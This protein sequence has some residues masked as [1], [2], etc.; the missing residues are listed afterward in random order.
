[1]TAATERTIPVFV[2][3]D[4]SWTVD[5]VIAAAGFRGELDEWWA[6]VRLMDRCESEAARRGEA[7]EAALQLAV[8]Q[9]RYERDLITA[10]ETENWLEARGLTLDDFSDHFIRRHWM[11][12]LGS[13]M[14]MSAP[15]DLSVPF[16]HRDWLR[17]ELLLSGGFEKMAVELSWRICV[18]EKDAAGM[19]PERIEEERAG[20]LE[21]TGAKTCE[22]WCARHDRDRNWLEEMLAAEAAYRME[23]KRVLTVPRG[24]RMLHDLR[25]PLTRVEL[26]ILEVECLAVAR[27]AV[28]CV[29]EDGACLE[30]VAREGGYPFRRQEVLIESLAPELQQ[31]ALCAAPGEVLEPMARG[32]GFNLA[33]VMRKTEPTL[34]DPEVRARIEREILE[35]HFRD[36]TASRVQWQ[37]G[38][39]PP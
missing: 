16:Q 11:E 24:E 8:E 25:M 19:M 5:D 18:V 27:E 38:F 3:G 23:A 32:D 34:N 39:A 20:F 28:L 30:E 35:H 1:M 14:E 6:Q 33:R 7:G 12:R 37:P 29:R 2:V 9:F 31:K 10:E 4:R 22:D 21:R 15:S 13:E 36:L 26:E 17:I